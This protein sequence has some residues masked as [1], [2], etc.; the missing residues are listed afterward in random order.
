MLGNQVPLG[1]QGSIALTIL[2]FGI[3][4]DEKKEA[5]EEFFSIAEKSGGGYFA[6][7]S[8]QE[9]LQTLRSQLQLGRYQVLDA[10]QNVIESNKKRQS[11]G[12]PWPFMIFSDFPLFSMIFHDISWSFMIMYMANIQIVNMIGGLNK[13]LVSILCLLEI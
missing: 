4:E 5:E 10:S 3:S 11:I 8:G 1:I 13:V 7:E 12:S 9:L 6:I 2:G